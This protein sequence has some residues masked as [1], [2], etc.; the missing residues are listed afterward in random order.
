MIVDCHTQIVDWE[1]SAGRAGAPLVS[2]ATADQTARY[3]EALHPVDRAIVLAFK[4]RYLATEVPNRWLA[5]CVRRYASKLIGFAGVDPTDRDCLTDLRVA[6]EEL[7]LKGVTL[8]PALQNFHP[9]DTRAM[10]LYEECARRGMPVLFEQNLRNPAAKLEYARPLLLDEVARE[11]PG[12]R[13]VVSHMGYPWIEETIVLIGKHPHVLADVAGLLR[14]P[15]LAYNA[16]L[17][18]YEHGVMPKLLFGS[19]FPQRQPASCIEALYSI[20]QLSHAAGLA[21]IPREALRG[22]VERDALALLGIEQRATG[23]V[24]ASAS[25]VMDED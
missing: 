23:A 19:D 2:E 21:A 7:G 17:S 18:A 9:C 13:I 5:E 22:I 1:T 15:W 11:F 10:R 20:N 25:D 12:L 24:R 8:S 6:Q 4:S 3:L 16:L 14:R